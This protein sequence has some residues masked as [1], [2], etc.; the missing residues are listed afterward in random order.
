MEN[1]IKIDNLGVPQFLETPIYFPGGIDVV[2][3]LQLQIDSL[4]FSYGG[5]HPAGTR[6]S[7]HLIFT[8]PVT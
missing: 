2:W 7:Y 5:N 8:Y 1:P 4:F 3:I 6:K